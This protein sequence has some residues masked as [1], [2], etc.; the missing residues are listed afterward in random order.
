M[1][2]YTH[3]LPRQLLRRWVTPPEISRPSDWSLRPPTLEGADARKGASM[4]P[5]TVVIEAFGTAIRQVATFAIWMILVAAVAIAIVTGLRAL[6]GRQSAGSRDQAADRQANNRRALTRRTLRADS[7]THPAVPY[8]RVAS[9]RDDGCTGQPSSPGAQRSL[10]R[11]G[12]S[13]VAPALADSDRRWIEPPIDLVTD[14]AIL[15]VMEE[16]VGHQPGN[17][18]S[19]ASDLRGRASNPVGSDHHPP[20][21]AG[22]AGAPRA[23]AASA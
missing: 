14:C 15:R 11:V 2:I 1:A 20:R 18:G 16:I 4:P 13:D 12:P 7:W 10:K 19:L 5:S 3:V 8:A 17:G 23:P 22:A 6:G 9:D 21:C